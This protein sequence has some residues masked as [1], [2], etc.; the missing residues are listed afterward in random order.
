MADADSELLENW[1]QER[2]R[3]MGQSVEETAD[4]SELSPE[5]IRRVERGEGR[6][7]REKTLRKL[8]KAYKVD[9]PA[10]REQLGKLQ[11]ARQHVDESARIEEDVQTVGHRPSKDEIEIFRVK[12]HEAVSSPPMDSAALDDW[13]LLADRHG[14]ATRY[15]PAQVQLADLVTDFASLQR[16]LVSRKTSSALRRLTRVAAQMAGLMFLTLIKLQRP[17]AARRW[18]QTTRVAAEEAGD[19]AIH[20]WVAAQEAYVHYY[21]GNPIAAIEVAKHAQR[22]A[23]TTTCVAVPLA[24]ALEARAMGVLR[25]DREARRALD[26]TERAMAALDSSALVRSA[27]GYDE[28]QLRFHEGNALTH[29][30][31]STGA[32]AAHQRAMLLYPEDDFLDLTL[33]QLDWATC[34]IHEGEIPAAMERAV[35]AFI[36]LSEN[37]RQGLVTARAQELVRSLTPQQQATRAARTLRDLLLQSS[38]STGRLE[39]RT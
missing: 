23:G 25:R 21:A 34:L 33:V 29:L 8:A 38:R 30:G 15:M 32:R 17:A 22:L 31:D 13:D 27:F 20:A 2:R 18:A 39:P 4:M 28:A 7:P 6:T 37:Q 12:I 11:A 26:Q 16:A 24:A 3:D 9:I 5:T 36:L 1:F 14:R 10:I 19:V 35:D